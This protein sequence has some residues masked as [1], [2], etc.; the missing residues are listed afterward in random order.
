[1]NGNIVLGR[2]TRDAA[3]LLC[4]FGCLFTVNYT[5]QSVDRQVFID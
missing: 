5:K 1:M 4:K 2:D 3:Y